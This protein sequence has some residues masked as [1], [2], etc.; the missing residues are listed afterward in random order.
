[1]KPYWLDDLINQAQ[2]FGPIT[3][4]GGL[5]MRRLRLLSLAGFVL[6]GGCNGQAPLL[7]CRK[8]CAKP[9]EERNLFCECTKLPSPGKGPIVTPT[10]QG[11]PAFDWIWDEHDGCFSNRHYYLLNYSPR[12]LIVTV[13]W[14]IGDSLDRDKRDY[15]IQGNR[16]SRATGIDLGYEEEGKDCRDKDFMLAGWREPGHASVADSAFAILEST[17]DVLYASRDATIEE[18]QVTRVAALG[19]LPAGYGEGPRI[20]FHQKSKIVKELK[21]PA[22]RDCVQLCDAKDPVNCP[23]RGYPPDQE[24][25]KGVRDRLRRPMSTGT[26]TASDVYEIFGLTKAACA[27]TDAQVVKAKVFN[28]GD[29]CAFPTFI[30]DSDSEPAASLHIPGAVKAE[31][32]LISD[33]TAGLAFNAGAGVPTLLFRSV[34]LNADFGGVVTQAVGGDRGVYYQTLTSCIYLGLK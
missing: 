14:R 9:D 34:D 5:N 28:T 8:P 3:T 32:L 6:I 27:R 18:L 4:D 22:P 7:T 10:P 33:A 20:T 17:S 25:L 26:Y 15:T 12:T 13:S 1:M 30:Q 2:H 16:T 31:K 23:V 29:Y 21:S 11:T 24:K 19:G